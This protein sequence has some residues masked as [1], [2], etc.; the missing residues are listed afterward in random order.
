MP[1][2]RRVLGTAVAAALLVVVTASGA[3]AH[4]ERDS[5]FPPGTKSTPTYRTYDASKPHLVVCKPDS[6]QRIAAL[7]DAKVKAFNQ[8][9]LPQCAFR[10][11]QAAVDAVKSQGTNIYLLPG[12]YREEPSYNPPCTKG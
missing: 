5:Q 1:A 6:A 11:I 7:T 12:T 3:A 8:K 9:L 2:V 4:E 10:H